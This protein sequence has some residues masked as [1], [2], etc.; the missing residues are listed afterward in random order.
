MK[1]NKHKVLFVDDELLILNSLKRLLRRESYEIKVCN[2]PIEALDL[3]KN[4]FFT[5]II[6]DERMPEMYGSEFLEQAKDISPK[7]LRMILS[8]YADMNAILNAINKGNIYKFI[9]KP[10]DDDDL[11][12]E[13]NL[14]LKYYNLQEKNLELS[15]C[16]K[17]K[18]IELDE[19]INNLENKSVEKLNELNIFQDLL[20]NLPIA[21]LCVSSE[22]WIVR[23]NNTFNTTFPNN[24]VISNDIKNYL[25]ES[26]F[27]IYYDVIMKNKSSR[28]NN[29]NFLNYKVNI[30]I[31]PMYNNDHS[32]IIIFERLE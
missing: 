19:Y 18:N 26:E 7:S 8:G 4:D 25:S 11:K 17:I 22:G 20:Y 12:N 15:E 30:S 1:S 6:S 10:W 24:N 2:S 27:K 29:C 16:I 5:L 9:N 23:A 32:S 28:I 14:A 13:I 3:I 31:I 21:Y